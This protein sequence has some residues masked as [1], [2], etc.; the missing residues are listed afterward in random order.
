MLSLFIGVN[1]LNSLFINIC[2]YTF[3]CRC[4]CK[5]PRCPEVQ[6]CA[7]VC[8]HG[9]V[10]DPTT[11]CET[12]TCKDAD[13]ADDDDDTDVH[14]IPEHCAGRPMC[15]MYCHYGFQKGENGCPICRCNRPP[16]AVEQLPK[17]CLGRIMCA[18]H[19]EYGFQ[20]GDDGC[21]ICRCNPAP[22]ALEVAAASDL[23]GQEPSLEIAGGGGGRTNLDP[24]PPKVK[25]A[26]ASG[27]D[28]Y[29]PTRVK[30][31]LAAAAAAGGETVTRVED[32]EG[33]GES[34][35]EVR[36][37][38]IRPNRCPLIRCMLACRYGFQRGEDG[39]PTCRCNPA[40]SP[41]PL[42]D[43]CPRF[44]CMIACQYGFQ[45]DE[46]GCNTCRCN[47]PSRTSLPELCR[48]RPM[49]RMACPNGF[50]KDEDGCPICRCK[51]SAPELP[52]ECN[53]PM[54]KMA[55]PN[56]FKKDEDGCPIC[57]CKPSAP[58]LPNRCSSRPWMCAMWCEHGFQKG[59]DGCEI[60]SC[61]RPPVFHFLMELE[62]ATAVG[63]DSLTQP[64]FTSQEGKRIIKRT[65]F[66]LCVAGRL[67][68]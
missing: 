35:P 44:R 19:C 63:T 29:E 42:P 34:Q 65:I 18:M 58:E 15:L 39:C 16:R 60:C 64:L 56:G 40:P 6:R 1:G 13:S 55:C 52:K 68:V 31:V 36:G 47:P 7:V 51:P 57:R 11:G 67:G 46:R 28:G 41:R 21:P 12:C 43:G 25:V 30:D 5:Q 61:N 45:T 48:N 33:G 17:H 49:C 8:A 9:H 59:P 4:R 54:C 20:T 26:V 53:R 23:A 37:G 2:L 66:H 50:E 62:A 14:Q 27:G 10:T 3:Y 38:R 32:A 22:V 24:R